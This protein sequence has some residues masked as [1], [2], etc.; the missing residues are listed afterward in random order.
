MQ[1]AV[2][3]EAAV[4]FLEAEW[5]NLQDGLGPELGAFRGELADVGRALAQRASR[6]P[7]EGAAERL[8]Q[9]L[10][11]FDCSR[12]LYGE[13]QEG[14]IYAGYTDL[15]HRNGAAG[16]VDFAARLSRRLGRLVGTTA[17]GTR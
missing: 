1:P 12:T 13:W 16:K 14:P 2:V 15:G 10:D 4:D 8:L 7:L 6:D 9:V 17:E 3:L 5:E 11:R